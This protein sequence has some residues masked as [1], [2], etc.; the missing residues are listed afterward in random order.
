MVTVVPVGA[1]AVEI[2]TRAVQLA[3]V[4]GFAADLAD[5]LAPADIA[6]AETVSALLDP[7]AVPP[8]FS[9]VVEAQTFAPNASGWV[10]DQ[11]SAW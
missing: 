2:Q 9:E 7:S 4:E 5:L 10:V 3:S 8:W 11:F 6:R 1:S